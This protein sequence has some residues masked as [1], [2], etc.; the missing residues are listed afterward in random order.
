MTRKILSFFAGLSITAGSLAGAGNL[1]YNG[2]FEITSGTTAPGWFG[3]YTIDAKGGVNGSKAARV[4][5]TD[6]CYNEASSRYIPVTPGAKFKLTGKY[7]GAAGYI[8]ILF[9]LPK[10]KSKLVQLTPKAAKVW[11]DFV[12]EGTVPEKAIRAVVMLRTWNKT[13]PLYFDDVRFESGNL[14]DQLKNGSFE[15]AGT[16]PENSAQWR[17]LSIRKAGGIDGNFMVECLNKG[18][19]CEANS[20]PFSVRANV[21]FLVEGMYKGTGWQLIAY[22][23]LKNKKSKTIVRHYPASRDWKYFD[24]RNIVPSDAVSCSVLLRCWDKKNA[25]NFDAVRFI[26]ENPFDRSVTAAGIEIILPPQVTAADL[27]AQKELANYLPKVIKGS[28]RI[29]GVPLK[30]IL[31]SIDNKGMKEEEWKMESKGDTLLLTGGGRRGT[32]FA[33]YH[34]LEDIVGIHWWN[35]WEE[36]VPA[37]KSWDIPAI[38]KRGKPYFLHRDLYRSG[39][40]RADGGQFAIRN[41]LNRNADSSVSEAFGGDGAYTWGPPYHAHTFARYIGGSYRKTNPEFFSMVDGERKGTQYSGQLCFTNK[42]LRK[43]LIKKVIANIKRT[44]ASAAANGTVEPLFYDLSMN[45]GTRFCEC[46][47]C[48]KIENASSITDL[49]IDFINEIAEGVEKVYPDVY[50]TTLAYGRTGSIP[51]KK[52]V[53]RKNVMIRYC[54][55]FGSTVYPSEPKNRKN[56]GY[57]HGWAKISKNFITWEHCLEVYPYPHE[58]GIAELLRNY[59]KLGSKGTFIEVGG[60]HY[61]LDFAD[62][63]NWLYCKMLEDPFSDFEAHRQTFLKCYFGKA[64]PMMDAYR[65]LLDKTQKRFSGKV[66]NRYFAE[67]YAYMNVQELIRAHKLFDEAEKAIAGDDVLMRRVINCRAPLNMLTA[68]MIGKYMDEWK[69]SGG[70]LQNFPIDQKKLAA[71]M[72][73]YW[74]READRYSKPAE[75][76]MIMEGQIAFVELL[77]G[78][79]NPIQEPAAFKGKTVRHFTPS[80][81]ILFRNANMRLVKD[82][83]AREG[84]A[85][86]IVHVTGTNYYTLPFQ[87]G[88]YDV[89]GGKSLSEK[90]WKTLPDGEGYHWLHVSTTKLN[91]GCYAYVT[92]SWCIQAKFNRYLELGEKKLDVW[93]RVKFEGPAYK[94]KGTKN[95]ILVDS[96]SV[97]ELD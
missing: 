88:T 78:E 49:L 8:Y 86:E 74:L 13:Q 41:R 96:I 72:R 94:K 48:K 37:A 20:A 97:V 22:F 59:A 54:N 87:A 36:Y 9:T 80:K 6:S 60:K 83:D 10:K 79:V 62:M 32:L 47:A 4:L 93:C 11:T 43:L 40:I 5:R 90:Q 51:P 77:T 19:Y 56:Q 58:M 52:V 15:T 38:S 75:D 16:K 71:N 18:S 35:K 17:G 3:G 7:K 45:D 46:P 25:V 57:L 30:K 66:L 73:K 23:T 1:L 42:E 2:S 76:R 81:L 67:C 27:T 89:P 91:Q 26:S 34:F 61:I 44:K 29:N 84:C 12:L 70:T 64:A 95:R 63:K 85:F 69:K 50:I 92:R 82:P 55:T 31:L 68:F 53:P 33:V 14:A 28:F 65:K 21:P 24:L 39:E